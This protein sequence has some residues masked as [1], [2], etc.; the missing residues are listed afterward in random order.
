MHEPTIEVRGL[1]K[2]YGPVTAVDD[3]TFTVP[4]GTVTALLGRN[5]AGKSTTLRMLL[6]LDQPTIGTAVIGGRPYADL[7]FPLRTVGALLDSSAAHPGRTARQHLRWLAASNS[8]G[9]GRIREVLELVGLSHVAHHRVNGFSLGM[10]QRLG[11]AAA[12]LGDP[13]VLLLDEPVNGLD[14]E[15]IRWLRAF[16]RELADQGRTVL[17]S[18][19]LMGEV[20]RTV[21]H[22]LVLGAGRLLA[23]MPLSDFVA[24]HAGIQVRVRTSRTRH[25]RDVLSAAGAAVT[26]EDGGLRASGMDAERI[27]ALAA[28]HGVPLT[29]LSTATHSLEDAFLELTDP[30]IERKGRVA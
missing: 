29:E 23:D 1:T 4:A 15:G 16:L 6:G 13:Q 18:S 24:E 26:E 30:A 10:R 9:D 14:A 7:P 22:V 25:L 19:H 2:K 11:M 27:G 12:L 28:Q 3:L 5:G 20:E 21:H 8:I 17:V